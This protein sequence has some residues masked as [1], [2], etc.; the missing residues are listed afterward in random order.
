MDFFKQQ[1]DS[2]RHTRW[3]V[4]YFGLG[5]A[6]ITMCLYLA[7]LLI[8]TGVTH[9]RRHRPAV[10]QRVE[11]WRPQL[12]LW[13]SGL[14]LSVIGVGSLS[15]ILELSQGGSVVATSLGGRLINPN[16]TNPDERKL[17]N[18]VE[19]MAI[20]SGIPVPQVYVLPG[21]RGINSFAAGNSPSDA[22]VAVTS[23]LRVLS[24][25]ELQGVIAH[26]FS[27]ILNGDMRLNL[28]LMGVIFGI[29]CLAVIGRVLLEVRSSGRDKNPLPLIGLALLL[30]GWIGVFFGRLIQAA[31]SRQ[32]EFLADASAVQF[33]RNP[34]GLASALKKIGGW[35]NG[36]QVN[37]AHATEASHLFFGSSSASGF[38]GFMETH[39]PLESRIRDLDPNFDGVYPKV[40]ASEFATA[41]QESTAV[42]APPLRVFPIPGRPNVAAI[43]GSKAHPV[44]PVIV[45][46][47]LLSTVGNPEKA[48]LRFAAT[49]H[50]ELSARVQMEARDPLGACAII[51]ALLLSEQPEVHQIQVTGLTE[52]AGPEAVAETLRLEGEIRALAAHA[53][54]PLVNLAMPALRLMSQ[55]QFEQFQA[56]TRGLIEADRQVDLF[57][58]MLQKIVVRHLAPH[59][60]EPPREAVEFYALRPLAQ[61]CAVLL[62]ALA[63]AGQTESEA[64]ATAFRRGAEVISYSA[65]TPLRLEE[66]SNC[67]L[68]HIDQALNRL[69]RAVPQ[70]R[71]L[72]LQSCLRTVAADELVTELEAELLRAI[73]DA[74]AC[75]LPPEFSAPAT[76]S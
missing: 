6:G 43:A 1:D 58:F 37:N 75:P 26:E 39:P 25:D 60:A 40:A 20:A 50:E 3:L 18:I 64:I 2:R 61:D 42:G 66:R 62:S 24:R 74:L 15:K 12:F 52:Q 38:W 27:H 36:S 34:L 47:G 46:S 53:K 44:A 59:F 32:R 5:V 67:E 4:I 68:A 30:I 31:V 22:A 56:A 17:L 51:Y 65:R 14:T 29:M 19:E 8:F 9:D 57:E 16:A 76:Q 23:A 71:K 73:A 28:R 72:T 54:L 55:S 41:P 63:Y 7:S 49:L 21:E 35:S 69:A 11:L 45:T 10:S 33:T 48:N 70:I 13:V